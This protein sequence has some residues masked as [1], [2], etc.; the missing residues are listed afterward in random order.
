MGSMSRKYAALM[1]ME[2]KMGNDQPLGRDMWEGSWVV[3]VCCWISCLPFYLCV[4]FNRL[5]SASRSLSHLIPS[6]TRFLPA[7]MALFSW[8]THRNREPC[9]GIGCGAG[10]GSRYKICSKCWGESGQGKED[11]VLDK[12]NGRK[13]SRTW[14]VAEAQ[15]PLSHLGDWRYCDGM[16]IGR[17]AA[18]G[19]GR[20]CRC[21]SQ[22]RKCSLGP[23]RA[24]S[25]A[26]PGYFLERHPDHQ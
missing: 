2:K 10:A 25:G 19:R 24:C 23:S 6:R 7:P 14:A 8:C 17:P 16:R 21:R 1:M 22:L 4:S 12:G 18:R 9:G 26:S 5:K 13:S 3:C 20:G 15:L 11:S